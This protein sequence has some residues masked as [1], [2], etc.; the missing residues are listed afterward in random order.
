MKKI[1]LLFITSLVCFNMLSQEKK[2]AYCEIVATG[3]TFSGKECVV[4]L[5]F[6]QDRELRQSQVLVDEMGEAIVFNSV[7]DALNWMGNLG[8]KFKQAYTITDSYSK[9]QIYH[10]LLA[11]EISDGEA[12]DKGIHLASKT[13][14]PDDEVKAEYAKKE[15]NKAYI[16]LLMKKQIINQKYK[17][18]ASKIFP[19]NEILQLMQTKTE[20]ELEEMS[21]NHNKYFDKYKQ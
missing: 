19:F 7:I 20:K 11:K 21:K 14:N 2:E 18:E 15:E 9:N 1:L 3:V 16:A 13:Q 5:D 10:F 8:W 12:I 6:G 17:E 4:T